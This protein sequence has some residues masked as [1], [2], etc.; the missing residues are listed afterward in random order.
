[1]GH[2]R[3]LRGLF[4]WPLGNANRSALIVAACVVA[5]PVGSTMTVKWIACFIAA[6]LVINACA[7]ASEPGTFDRTLPVSGPV[8]LDI[9]S[10]PGGIHITS[11]SSSS[12]V[13][14]AVIRSVF[15]RVDLG[16]AEANIL[17]L[18]QNPPLEQNG[19][20][21]RIG[22]VKNE[23]LLKGV[24][25]TYDIQTPR[26][27]RVHASADA[28]GIHIAGVRGPV[29]TVNSAGLSEASDVE[30]TLK[31]T[32]RAG[33]I[34]IRNAGN[35]VF[36][37]N[38]SGGIQMQGIHGN[39]DAATGNGRIEITDVNGDVQATTR[40]ASIRIDNIKGAVDAHNTS[41]SIEAFQ[42]AGSVRAETSSGSIR[43]SQV[44]PAP[45]RALTG[46]GAIRVELASGGG[47]TLD[48][49]SEKGKISGKATDG[50]AKTKEHEHLLKGEISSGG[51]LVDLDTRSSKIEIN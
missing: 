49:Q 25:I 45:I 37:R 3:Q 33:G 29:E 39:V 30:A 40:S 10:G 35:Q 8:I 15:G 14:H 46:S 24:T 36:V 16:V 23:G 6:P 51:P 20:S 18:Q 7:L 28:G 13:V 2:L 50:F 1:M 4:Y 9:Q 27:T 34:V 38:E 21:I 42:L 26:E 44:S 5:V 41:G 22:Y 17:A 47:Y 31:M 32:S 11:G 19:N 43:I 12:V 48:A